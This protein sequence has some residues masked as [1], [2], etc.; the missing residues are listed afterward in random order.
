MPIAHP[1]RPGDPWGVPATSAPKLNISC[2][3]ARP[4]PLVEPANH[5]REPN[6]CGERLAKGRM[7]AN[8]GLMVAY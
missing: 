1:K 5:N 3:H 7:D 6:V 4:R 2:A 8:G